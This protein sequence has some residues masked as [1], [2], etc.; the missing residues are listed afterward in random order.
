[1]CVFTV[2]FSAH[3]SKEAADPAG[4]HA[5]GRRVVPRGPDATD[6][7]AGCR[8]WCGGGGARSDRCALAPQ[9]LPTHDS[10]GKELSKGQAK[11]LRKL[12]EAQERLHLE[13]LQLVQNGG[14][15]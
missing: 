13:Y 2:C 4:H 5:L 10:E 14:P 6:R 11:K 3:T 8:V 15:P 9:G 1:M 7:G 12:F